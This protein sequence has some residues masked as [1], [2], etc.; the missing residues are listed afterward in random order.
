MIIELLLECKG[1][2]K[3]Y[4]KKLALNDLNLKVQT[5]QIVGLLG[6]NG[7]GKTTLMKLIVSLL[8]DYR[9]SIHVNGMKPSVKTKQFV[10]YLPDREFLYQWMTIEESIAFF[11][12]TFSDFEPSK[13]HRMIQSLGLN[14]KD[15]IRSL[16]KGMQERLSIS[17]IFS[18]N[19]R[20]F[21]LDEPLAA[22]DPSTREKI[23]NIILENFDPNSSIIVST[24][25][26]N[27]VESLFT[28]IAIVNDGKVLL[29][30]EV[31]ELKHT[32]QKSIEDIFKEIV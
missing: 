15:K 9:G 28:H 8:R 12:H 32:Y 22:V 4:G 24:H 21:V 26:I 14:P 2:V 30:G 29:Q 3:K 17:L 25:L 31:H 11:N 27:E 6:P 20:L 13:A 23:L 19:A 5:G 1:V 18:R 16:S 7:A 10:A